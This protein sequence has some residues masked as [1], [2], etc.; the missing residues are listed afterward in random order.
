[1][2]ERL[3]ASVAGRHLACHASANLEKA[4]YGWVPPEI[5]PEKGAKGLGTELHRIFAELNELQSATNLR[6]FSQ[7]LGYIADLR[8]QRRWKMLLEESVEIDWLSSKPRTTA[9]MVLYTQD[10]L[11]VV[12]LKTG[13]IPVDPIDN[14]QLLYYACAYA[15][16]APKAKGATLHI[17]QPW[18]DNCTSWYASTEV[19]AQFAADLQQ[20]DREIQAGDVTFGPSDHCLFCPAYPHSRGDK[21]KPLCPETMKL[22]Y[23]DHL[24]ENEIINS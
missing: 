6:K 21:G 9:D 5:D 23:P 11:H 1:M 24:N 16:L 14:E 3:S 18:A 4:I 2:I 17:V 12:D 15:D 10:E 13:A 22:L 7:A 19:L 20:A 8:S